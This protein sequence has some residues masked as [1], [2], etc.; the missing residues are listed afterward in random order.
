MAK[1]KYVVSVPS[2]MCGNVAGELFFDENVWPTDP[3]AELKV[4]KRLDC[5]S[6][7][8]EV[9]CDS[10]RIHRRWV[11]EIKPSKHLNHSYTVKVNAYEKNKK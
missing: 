2:K 6:T 7:Q 3:H 1:Q 5:P 9:T 8:F 11:L 4:A 10:K